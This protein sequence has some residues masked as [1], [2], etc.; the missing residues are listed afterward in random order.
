MKGFRRVKGIPDTRVVD[1]INKTGGTI[2]QNLMELID[3]SYDSIFDSKTGEQ[4]LDKLTVSVD[5]ETATKKELKG[6][7][8]W[9]VRDNGSGILD[10]DK[11]WVYG[12]SDKK[13]NLGKFGVGLKIAV[14]SLGNE[15]WIS[16]STQ[17]SPSNRII[18]YDKDSFVEENS[19]DTFHDDKKEERGKRYTEI[20][21]TK[22]YSEKIDFKSIKQELDRT[23]YKLINHK[24]KILFNKRKLSWNE[25]QVYAQKEMEGLKEKFNIPNKPSLNEIYNDFEFSLYDNNRKEHKIKGWIGIQK[26]DNPKLEGFDIFRANRLIEGNSSFGIGPLKQRLYGQIEL[27]YDFPVSFHKNSID[28]SDPLSAQLDKKLDQYVKHVANLARYMQKNQRWK[29]PPNRKKATQTH[30]NLLTNVLNNASLRKWL[31]NLLNEDKKYKKSNEENENIGEIHK[32]TRDTHPGLTEEQKKTVKKA[33]I[34]KPKPRKPLVGFRDPINNEMIKFD[35]SEEKLGDDMTISTHDE[36]PRGTLTIMTN[37]DHPMFIGY[38]KFKPRQVSELNFQNMIHE[39]AKYMSIKHGIER[40]DLR[41]QINR[42]FSGQD[43]SKLK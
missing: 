29:T 35:F 24:I 17:G 3:N 39:I 18:F 8:G 31:K 13:K 36:Y 7:K 15:I 26:S 16:S 12:H 2:A 33:V 41:D 9:Y 40:D 4:N 20:F 30:I 19:W 43:L 22:C 11:V 14:T 38:N 21:V 28:R 37:V 34:T 6:K 23:Y 25:P 27:G 32:V 10:P 5:W 1:S 42:L